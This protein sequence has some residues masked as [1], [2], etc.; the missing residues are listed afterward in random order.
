[1]TSRNLFVQPRPFMEPGASGEI[2]SSHRSQD[3]RALVS[4]RIGQVRSRDSSA[5]C[6]NRTVVPGRVKSAN[7]SASQLVSRTQ[8]CDEALLIREGSGVP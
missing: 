6:K 8:P 7:S 3:L 4:P 5:Y 2:E 1:M